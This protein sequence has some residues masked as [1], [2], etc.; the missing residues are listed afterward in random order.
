MGYTSYFSVIMVVQ[1]NFTP[2]S[3][4]W[5]IVCAMPRLVRTAKAFRSIIGFKSWNS[6][7]GDQFSSSESAARVYLQIM[8]LRRVISRRPSILT[9][10]GPY[11]QSAPHIDQPSL[12]PGYL[13]RLLD[14]FSSPT[15]AYMASAH[16]AGFFQYTTTLVCACGSTHS[17]LPSLFMLPRISVASFGFNLRFKVLL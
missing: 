8:L 10:F 15:Q 7:P 16:S 13:I 14:Y 9:L 12:K 2:I 5:P 3:S 11:C 17:T 4:S 6:A 1:K